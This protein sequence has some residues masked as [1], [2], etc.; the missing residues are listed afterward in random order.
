MKLVDVRLEHI[1]KQYPGVVAADDVSLD[2]DEGSFFTL[3]GPSGCGKT[4]LLRIIAGF[5]MQD[6]GD[7]YF[8]DRIINDVP[9][10]KRNTGL[11][12]QTYALWPHMRVSGNVAFG[13]DF[14]GTISREEK[15]RRVDE[16]LRLVGLEGLEDRMPSQLSGGQQQRVAL[17]RALVVEPDVLLLDEPLSNL[18]ARLRV[19]MRT[20]I[21]RIQRRLGITAIYVTHDQE[22]ALSISDEI[23]VL[24]HGAVQQ[25]G[26]PKSI[27]EDPVN[28]FVAGF[29][30][31]A[32]FMGGHISKVGE[33]G[34]ASVATEE[35]PEIRV[36]LEAGDSY[37][38]GAKLIVS[39]RPEAIAVRPRGSADGQKNR[40][41]GVIRL[42]S[43]LGSRIRYEVE[44][45]WGDIF[46]V[47]VYN[48]R[49]QRL[50]H[51]GELVS[52]EFSDH[53][54][55]LIELE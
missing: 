1:T 38:E 55:N 24:N 53:D 36:S 45:S 30:G 2:I 46:R 29:I 37:R 50:F 7:V 15:L 11:V 32:N 10:H 33:G 27:Y 40:I 48:P 21:R 41:D 18:D 26:G 28:D 8:G 54:V 42:A 13:L 4:T 16:A 34:L 31:L 47:D 9:P 35:G 20:E 12:F 17:A 3:L 6:E 25:E 52:L 19:Q 51:E 22:E 44:V 23:A 39:V 49:H 14:R 5:T 43:Y